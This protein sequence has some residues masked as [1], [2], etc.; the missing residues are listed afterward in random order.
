MKQNNK[1]E[2]NHQTQKR[3]KKRVKRLKLYWYRTRKGKLVQNPSSE[4]VIKDL[5]FMCYKHQ[6]KSCSCAMCSNR[7]TRNERAKEKRET[8]K[9]INKI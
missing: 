5:G 4:F 1:G 3:Y 6:G 8:Y 2:R 7:K 9:I